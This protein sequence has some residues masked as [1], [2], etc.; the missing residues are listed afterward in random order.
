MAPETAMGLVLVLALILAATAGPRPEDPRTLRFPDGTETGGLRGV[1]GCLKAFETVSKHS[2]AA[3]VSGDR[4]ND[5]TYLIVK[6]ASSG[7]HAV[8]KHV[9]SKDLHPWARGPFYTLRAALP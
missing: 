1:T 6:E 8:P 2:R 9:D 5:P 7:G 4:S 3:C